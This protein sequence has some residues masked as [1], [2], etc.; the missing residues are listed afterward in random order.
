MLEVV[1]LGH[2]ALRRRADP[3]PEVT[4]ELRRLADDMLAVM[5]HHEGIGLAATQVNRMVRLFVTRAPE[6]R[7]R[8]FINPEIVRTGIEIESREEGCLSIPGPRADVERPAHV[9][10][11]ARN[12]RGRLFSLEAEGMLARVI[13]HELDHLNGTL[14][15]DH[16][17]DEE[18]ERVC[19]EYAEGAE[20]SVEDAD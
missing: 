17:S 15:I 16:L 2:P 6:D 9:R 5:K 14:F 7:E 8:V 3:V 13:Q 1:T 4:P 12:R 20:A 19:R 18:R 11:Q 10:V